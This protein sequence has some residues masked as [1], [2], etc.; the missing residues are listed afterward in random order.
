MPRLKICGEHFTEKELK[1][2]AEPLIRELLCRK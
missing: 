2:A 1:V